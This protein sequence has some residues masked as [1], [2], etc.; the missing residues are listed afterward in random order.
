MML[1]IDADIVVYRT[2]CA[3][4]TT[5]D[6][7]DGEVTYDADYDQAVRVL[8]SLINRI[9]AKFD[10]PEML[11]CFSH[12]K[13]FRKTVYPDYKSNRDGIHRP[14]LL[15][16]LREYVEANYPNRNEKFLEADDLL[17]ILATSP[18][19]EETIIVT[20]DKDLFQIPAKVY[21]FVTDDIS[22][23]EDRDGP[24]LHYMQTLM[25]DTVDGYK[26]CPGVGPKAAVDILNNP[27]LC[28]SY[29][30]EFKRGPRKGEIETRWKQGEPCTVWEAI[31][32]RF[33]KA[34]LTEKE[35]LVQAR[36][37]KILQYEDYPNNKIK[38]WEPT[39][40]GS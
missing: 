34:G 25:G 6:W 37:A 12:K 36:I 18:D 7:G 5:T 31:V 3:V 20:I 19:E 39:E 10:F 4:E 16:K 29:E 9:A 2:A 11:F 14:I 26:G 35:A 23:P 33:E 27:T 17:G 21:N 38:L 22:N 1:L 30:H 28:E 24:R 40:N 15:K 8:E 32:S 13:N